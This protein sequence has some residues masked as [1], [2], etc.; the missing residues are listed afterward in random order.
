MLKLHSDYDKASMLQLLVKAGL[1]SFITF[2]VCLKAFK[3]LIE[4]CQMCSGIFFFLKTQ[5]HV[6]ETRGGTIL[7][8]RQKTYTTIGHCEKAGLDYGNKSRVSLYLT[9]DTLA[10]APNTNIWPL[11]VPHIT[12]SLVISSCCLQNLHVAQ[13]LRLVANEEW[14]WGFCWNSGIQQCMGKLH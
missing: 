5:I 4:G 13:N 6:F 7:K 12:K 11:F 1:L 2:D 14:Y 8:R 9:T 3:A 10:R